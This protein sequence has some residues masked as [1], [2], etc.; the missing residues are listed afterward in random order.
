MADSR[1]AA[2]LSVLGQF[3]CDDHRALDG[4]FDAEPIFGERGEIAGKPPGRCR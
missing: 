4:L 2:S 3:D 1:A